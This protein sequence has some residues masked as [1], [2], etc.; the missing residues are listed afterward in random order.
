ML[1]WYN[2]S[3]DAG[4][5]LGALGGAA[6]AVLSRLLG[7]SALEAH[8]VTFLGLRR[9]GRREHCLLRPAHRVRGA[10]AQD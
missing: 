9:R 5:A 10:G 3:L 1:A 8:R 4:H 7:M 6:P 2:L